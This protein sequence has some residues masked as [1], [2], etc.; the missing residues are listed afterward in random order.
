MENSLEERIRKAVEYIKK[1]D[2]E[3][4]DGQRVVVEE[5]FYFFA[6]TY[7]TKY[8]EEVFYEAHKNYVDIQY[9]VEGT[10]LI[11]TAPVGKLEVETPYSAEK[12]IGFYRNNR[13]AA[14]FVLT[15]GG[16]AV[17]YPADAHKPGICEKKPSVVRK[18]VGKI[19]VS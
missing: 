16:Y 2:F 5:G 1:I 14:T 18:I 9:I 19:K 3:K 15:A 10:E 11:Q 6:Q 4:V 13:D 17:L 12:D 7:T 8:P